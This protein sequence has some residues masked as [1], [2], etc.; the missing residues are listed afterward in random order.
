MFEKVKKWITDRLT[1]LIQVVPAQ[2]SGLYITSPYTFATQCIISQ[3]WYGGE[4]AELDQL[5]KQTD[6]ELS[7]VNFWAAASTTGINFRKI[8]SGL[9]ALIVN[10]LSGIVGADLAEISSDNPEIDAL[11]SGITQDNSLFGLLDAAIADV[12]VYG[13]GAAK[14][15]FDPE[16]SPYP[17]IEFY[18]APDVE[19]EYTRGRLKTICFLT[20][21]SERNRDYILEERYSEGAIEC[22]VHGVDG[23]Y[24]VENFPRLINKGFVSHYA[25]SGDYM[26]AA[27]LVFFCSKR[28]PGRGKSI[29]EGKYGAFDALDEVVSQWIEDTRAG[30][31]NTYI[32]ESMIPRSPETGVPLKSNP[33][34]NRFISIPGSLAEDSTDKIVRERADARA[35]SLQATYAAFLELALQGIL[36][37]STLGI[38]LKKTDNAEAQREKEKTTVNTRGRIVSALRDFVTGLVRICVNLYFSTQGRT[39]PK[40]EASVVFGEY[41]NP[42]FESR[43]ETVG[44]AKSYQ[45]ISVERAVEELWGSDLDDEEKAAEVRRLKLEDGLTYP[46]PAEQEAGNMI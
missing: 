6:D 32:P 9:P 37:P 31:M 24:P 18:P 29:F 10:T 26:L 4:P 2:N 43:V 45:I 19:F 8:H 27:P 21:F 16:L 42:S 40:F 1:S 38:D 46:G 35:E 30:R 11:W 20:K 33:F 22:V 12:L 14:I 41:A 39:P 25:F 23:D 36:S 3:T 34:D 13:D 5:Y 17:I 7:N 44:K 28:Y 15:G